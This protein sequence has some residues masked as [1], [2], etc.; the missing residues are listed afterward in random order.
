M[1]LCELE[2]GRSP[3]G[4]SQSGGWILPI[5]LIENQVTFLK[6]YDILSVCTERRTKGSD[7]I[8]SKTKN[9]T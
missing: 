2:G 4:D 7:K 5:K 8:E 3:T 6:K 9:H 1:P